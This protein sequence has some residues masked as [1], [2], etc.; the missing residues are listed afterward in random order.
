MKIMLLQCKLE[1][2]S[3]FVKVRNVLENNGM[4]VD[5]E[6]FLEKDINKLFNFINNNIS[7]CNII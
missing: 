3:N 4:Y 5:D 1:C 2:N 6:S 7:G